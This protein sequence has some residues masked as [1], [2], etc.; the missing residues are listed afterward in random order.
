MAVT[1]GLRNLR[2]LVLAALLAGGVAGLASAAS[3]TR[4]CSD[5]CFQSAKAEFRAC[6]SSAT[7][8]FHDALDGCLERDHECVQACRTRRQDCRDATGVGAGLV[9]CRADLAARTAHC[10]N[11]FRL[12]SKQ[13]EDCIDRAQVD[14]FHCQNDVRRHF[15]R[16]LLECHRGFGQCTDGCGP[17]G[18]PGGSKECR[19]AGRSAFEMV[20]AD[21]HLTFQVTA[22][23]CFNKDVTCVQ[24]CADARDVCTAPTQAALESALAACLMQEVAALSACR[25]A[26]PGGGTPLDQC[27]TAAQAAAATCRDDALDAAAPGFAACVPPYVSCVHGCPKP[28]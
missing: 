9:A 18:P 19:D 14:N 1:D 25:A 7:G 4:L 10:R 16:A 20:V 6:S 26:N 22:N 11:K 3:T 8:A 17:G 21:C 24:S 2:R 15:R 5:P 13:R 12:G 27:I 23:A 28:S